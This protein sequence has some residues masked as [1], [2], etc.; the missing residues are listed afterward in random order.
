[1]SNIGKIIRVNALPPAG[2]RETNVI[3]QVAAL[4]AATYTDYA[5]D[6]NGDLKTHAVVDG[7]I[8]LPLADSHIGISDLDLISE[9][10]T[11]QSEYNVTMREAL[12]NKLD[13]PSTDGTVQDYPKIIG[14][15]DNGNTAKL[16]AGDLGRNIANSSLTSVPGAGLTLGANWTLDTSGLYYSI[17]GLNDVSNDATF[18]TYLSQNATGRIGKTNG[19]QP[20]L[21]LPTT[22]TE[23]ERTAWKTAM[24]G[25]WTTATMSVAII[26]PPVVD[27]QE[28][29]YWITLKG[30]NLN[31][32]PMSFTVDIM[33]NDGT[34][35]IATVPNSQVQLY[36]NGI[37]LTFYYN[38]KNLAEGQYKI[39][40]W[41]GVA[42]YTTSLT[43]TVVAAL[44]IVDV[45]TLTWTKKIYND[46]VNLNTF[47]NGGSAIYQ[48]SSDVKAYSTTDPTIVGALKS[49]KI[50][51]IGDN[52]YLEFLVNFQHIHNMTNATQ[53]VGLMNNASAVDLLDQ[54]LTRIKAVGILGSSTGYRTIFLN[55]TTVG[56]TAA[57]AIGPN[58]SVNV[59][60][61]KNGTSMT[62]AVTARGV[63]SL[64]TLSAPDIEYSLNMAVNNMGGA[65]TTS[66]NV[67]NLY[68]F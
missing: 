5:I 32:P 48:S 1:M 59:V 43:I 58:E 36:T 26:T 51:D 17:T 57:G 16:P 29:N 23:S 19:K 14:I 31:L 52:F 9:G 34:T 39:R 6:E 42:Y 61:I 55:N 68:K 45:S 12:E 8:S 65:A 35:L 46:A 21:N 60:I 33:A 22:L 53:Y 40:L 30:A 20:F 44:S 2:E 62:V 38:F 18:D 64:S 11:N 13:N 25:G 66:L 56:A 63:T 49:S 10:I 3:Y 50:N 47:G 28:K 37:D 41:N 7:S 27:K 4:G 54:T 24:N 67:T 15:D